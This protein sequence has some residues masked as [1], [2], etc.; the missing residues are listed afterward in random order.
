[1]IPIELLHEKSIGVFVSPQS[2]RISRISELIV[3]P[4]EAHI[5]EP[6][7]PRAPWTLLLAAYNWNYKSGIFNTLEALGNADIITLTAA[8]WDI[9][10][11]QLAR[12]GSLALL[13]KNDNNGYQALVSNTHSLVGIKLKDGELQ[14]AFSLLDAE[15]VYN[16]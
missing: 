14:L 9:D 8:W 16:R 7:E 6:F 5:H 12:E 3:L 11:L 4:D 15:M 13:Q 10:K 1:M 2:S